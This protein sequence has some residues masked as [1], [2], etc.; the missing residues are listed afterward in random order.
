MS[1]EDNFG[2]N[3]PKPF[4]I[5]APMEG[6]GELRNQLTDTKSTDDVRRLGQPFLELA[7]ESQAPVSV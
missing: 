1:I 3:L 6:A 5:L 2:L 4:F 7:G